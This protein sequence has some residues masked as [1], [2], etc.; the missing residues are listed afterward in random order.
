MR[1]KEDSILLQPSDAGAC[2]PRNLEGNKIQEDQEQEVLP[3]QIQALF[4]FPSS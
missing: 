1:E 4:S 3:N 2:P